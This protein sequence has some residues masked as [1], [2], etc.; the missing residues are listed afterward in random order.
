MTLT[1][2]TVLVIFLLTSIASINAQN[3][4]ELF[5]ILKAK[6]NQ[7]FEVGFNRCNLKQV[8][9]LV[10][11]DIEFYHDIDGVTKS[12]KKFINSIKENLC[13][14][15]KNNIRRVLDEASFEVFPLYK[16]GKLYGAVQNG[17]HRF[18]Q[19]KANYSHL[20]LKEKQEWKLSRVLSY[21]HHKE[22]DV[23]KNNRLKLSVTE[24]K[25]YVGTYEFSPEFILTIRIKDGKLYGGSQGDEVE[26]TSYKKHK[27]IDAEQTHDLEFILNKKGIVSSLKMKGDGMEM[28]ALKQNNYD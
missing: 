24:L 14:S 15:G 23:S 28:I 5:S 7:L 3:K 22:Q 26:I 17:I 16:D 8:E 2:K 20:W 21:N 25:Q 18:G 11:N 12:K 19:T 10:T 27:F 1:L 6:D 9:K 4:S 13:S